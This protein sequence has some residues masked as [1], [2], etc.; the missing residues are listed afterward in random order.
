[1]VRPLRPN[2]LPLE[3]NGRWNYGMLEKKV[4]RKVLFFLNGPALY[5][6]PPLLMVRQLREELFCGFPYDLEKN[7]SFFEL[8]VTH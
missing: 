8:A 7:V 6:P 3:L 2:P 4:P 5:Q 1:M